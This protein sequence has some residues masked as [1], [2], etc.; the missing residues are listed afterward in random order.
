M[1]TVGKRLKSI[2]ALGVPYAVVIG[3]EITKDPPQIEIQNI[4]SKTK[5]F[6]HVN[7]VLPF[8]KSMMEDNQKGV[9][10]EARDSISN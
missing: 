3:K 9:G 6:V 2:E 10:L 8:L 5:N 7:D 1:W 4:Y